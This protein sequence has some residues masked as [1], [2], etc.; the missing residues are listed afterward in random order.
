MFCIRQEKYKVR[1]SQSHNNLTK[2]KTTNRKRNENLKKSRK[3]RTNYIEEQNNVRAFTQWR[4][5]FYM[6]RRDDAEIWRLNIYILSKTKKKK[7]ENQKIKQRKK[8]ENRKT[9]KKQ[10]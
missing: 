5:L 1:E 3:D 7:S 6:T 4:I 8:R 10:K 9:K 2:E